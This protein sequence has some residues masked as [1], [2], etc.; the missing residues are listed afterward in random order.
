[1]V[2]Q[3][4]HQRLALVHGADDVQ[5]RQPAVGQLLVHQRL[6][7]D[8]DRL[9]TD[10]Q[11]RVGEDAHE[12]DVAGAEDEAD[13]TAGQQLAEWPGRVAVLRTVP[14][15]RPAEDTQ[16]AHAHPSRLVVVIATR[17]PR[18]RVKGAIPVP[19]GTA[20]SC[21]FYSLTSCRRTFWKRTATR[22]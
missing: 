19:R 1:A 3:V 17:P 4:G 22:S 12:A 10:A 13:A 20:T 11:Y 6:R 9:A 21:L 8:A 16:A 14:G 18:G 5:R 2:G 15:A 7:D